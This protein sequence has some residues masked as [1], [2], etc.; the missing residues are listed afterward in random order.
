M[1]TTPGSAMMMRPSLM[2][3]MMVTSLSELT[4]DEQHWLKELASGGG[5][6][7]PTAM[8]KR[9]KDLGLAEQKLGGVGISDAGKRLVMSRRRR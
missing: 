8:A 3:L 4:P 7:I 9:L 2:E 6:M 1:K 5:M